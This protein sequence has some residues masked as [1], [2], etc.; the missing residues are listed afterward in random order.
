MH[1]QTGLYPGDVALDTKVVSIWMNWC[2]PR[3]VHKQKKKPEKK[4][5]PRKKKPLAIKVSS[6]ITIIMIPGPEWTRRRL[7]PS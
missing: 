1:S 3:K 7:Q 2:K 4:K 6:L 5:K